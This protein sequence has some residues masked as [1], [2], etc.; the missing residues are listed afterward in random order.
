MLLRLRDYELVAGLLMS[1]KPPLLGRGGA[2]PPG[3]LAAF[4]WVGA[5]AGV[6]RCRCSVWMTM[7]LRMTGCLREH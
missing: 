5:A 7:L 1:C 6:Q 3:T 2:I 4:R